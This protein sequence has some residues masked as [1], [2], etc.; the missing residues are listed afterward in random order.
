MYICASLWSWEIHCTNSN[1]D[2]SCHVDIFECKH[3]LRYWTFV[4][5]IHRSPVNS[6]HKGQWQGALM[7]SFICVW[8]NGWVNNCEA[9]D[10]RRYHAHYD[11]IV[12]YICTRIWSWEVHCTK[13]NIDKSCAFVQVY[14]HEKYIV[15]RVTLINHVHK[16]AKYEIQVDHNEWGLAKLVVDLDYCMYWYPFII[17][18]S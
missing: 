2:K 8:I 17:P 11:V 4:Q 13:S 15:P 6:P 1:I 10:L 3:F 16:A 5:G 12:M 14:D 9:G 7:F 18:K